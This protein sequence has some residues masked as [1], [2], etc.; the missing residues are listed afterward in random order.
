MFSVNILVVLDEQVM[1]NYSHVS[2]DISQL[3]QS[4]TCFH[5]FECLFVG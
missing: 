2:L 5:L 1:S 4:V 3:P